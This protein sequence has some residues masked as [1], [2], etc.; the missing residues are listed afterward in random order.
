MDGYLLFAP[1]PASKLTQLD[2]IRELTQDSEVVNI[3]YDDKAA[4]EITIGDDI[5]MSDDEEESGGSEKKQRLDDSD[6]NVC[7]EEALKS[8]SSLKSI[9]EKFKTKEPAL[10]NDDNAFSAALSSRHYFHMLSVH[11]Y[12]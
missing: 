3:F 2:R 4:S 12:V 9:C 10:D 6:I 8:H 7:L 1:Y 11:I 5:D